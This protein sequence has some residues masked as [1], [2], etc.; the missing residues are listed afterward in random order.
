MVDVFTEKQIAE[1][2]EAF[3]LSDKDGDGTYQ[4]HLSI[5]FCYALHLLFFFFGFVIY[6]P[7]IYIYIY[8]H[9]TDVLMINIC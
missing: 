1:F 4:T 9:S 2:Q 6:T 8:T 3:C 7:I 5:L